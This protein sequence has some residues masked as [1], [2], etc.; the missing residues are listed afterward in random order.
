MDSLNDPMVEWVVFKS[1]SQVGKSE[2]LLNGIGFHID[3]D[4]A[5]M[6]VIQP[7]VSPMAED[8]ATDRVDTMIRDSPS[9]HEKV[10]ETKSTKLK[11]VFPNGHCTII[12]AN[13]AAGLASRP[14]RIIWADELDRWAA[15]VGQAKDDGQRGE[16]DPLMLA[17]KR[18]T[19]Y[20]NR[21]IFCVSTPTVK[22]AS[23]ISALYELTDKRMFY[24]P[25]PKCG[26]AHVLRWGNVVWGKDTPAQGDPSR[27]VLQCPVCQKFYTDAEKQRAIKTAEKRGGGW[28]ATAPFAGKRGYWI[29]ELYSPWSSVGKMA[30]EFLEA[31]HAGPEKLQVFVNTSLGEEWEG[32]GET[33]RDSDLIARCEPYGVE[34]PGRA[35]VLTIGA[36]VQRDRVEAEV[37]GWGAGEESWSVD[38]EVFK[39]DPDIPEGEPGSP[40]DAFTAYRRKVWKHESGVEV[41]PEACCIDSGGTNTKAVYDYVRAHPGETLYAIKGQPGEG[42]P[43]VGAA[44]K[45][46]SGKKGRK[47]ELYMVGVDQAKDIIYKRL[48]ISESGPGYCHFPLGRSDEWFR[49]VTA[50]KKVTTWV[51]GF[52][53]RGWEKPPTR[54]NEALDCRVYGF[55]ALMF[56][57]P[58]W[59]KLA[60]K[61]KQRAA[62]LAQKPKAVSKAELVEAA[63]E[64]D[65]EHEQPEPP[66]ESAQDARPPSSHTRVEKRRAMERRRRGSFMSRW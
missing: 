38:Y 22:D 30:V 59:D 55:A 27:A 14:I 2:A 42:I 33:V 65:D 52:P 37:I 63:Q 24:V 16:G 15:S 25:C 50:E 49:Q 53:R 35:M 51:K 17:A 44:Q 29:N 43:L 7:N 19:T 61:L 40:W 62:V 64:H 6:L 12:G 66:Q 13:S 31:K 3:H 57:N 36:D 46:R 10:S 8:F 45:K 47:V 4:P 18:T 20:H 5:P 11:K 48:Q 41:T 56:V 28:R 23:R 21:K 32:A 58:K 60:F 34:V 1:S 39:G 9:L 26:D 54:R